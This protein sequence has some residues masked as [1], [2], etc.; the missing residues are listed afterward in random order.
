[1]P[2]TAGIGTPQSQRIKIYRHLIETIRGLQADLPIGLC[3]EERRIFKELDMA[4]S[5][6][7]L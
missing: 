3:L 4:A 1:M 2:V 6:A 7:S 5:I